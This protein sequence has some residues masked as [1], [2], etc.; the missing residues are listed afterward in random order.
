VRKWLDYF[1]FILGYISEENDL[2]QYL[3]YC[4]GGLMDSAPKE[5]SY[6]TQANGGIVSKKVGEVTRLRQYFQE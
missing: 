4:F 6:T 5:I 2:S 1:Q 3:S